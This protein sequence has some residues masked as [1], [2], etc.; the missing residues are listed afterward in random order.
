LKADSGEIKLDPKA[1]PS[2][3]NNE[4]I[5]KASY[6][7]A[8]VDYHTTMMT[9]TQA[10]TERFSIPETLVKKGKEDD[11][12]RLDA[13]GFKMP[14]DRFGFSLSS[15]SNPEQVYVSVAKQSSLLMMDKFMQIDFQLPSQRLFGF[16]E[17][18]RQ[19]LLDQGT[20]TM[21]ASGQAAAYDG[22]RGGN[23][24]SGVHPFVLVQSAQEDEFLGIFFR[25]SNAQSPIITFNEDGTSTLS[26]VTTGGQIEAYFFTGG[27]A[28][29]VIGRYHALIGVPMPPPF[30]ALGWQAASEGYKTQ[31][32]LEA[33]VQGF[34]AADLPVEGFWLGASYMDGYRDFSV[35]SS[36]FKNLGE[37]TQQL[38]A[39][40]R[41]LIVVVDPGLSADAPND[42][43][44]R[45]AE[46]AGALLQST[47]NPDDFGGALVHHVYSN[48]TVFLDFLSDQAVE[49]WS[50]GL[51][52]LYDEV[53]YDGLWLDMNEVT[54]LCD[55]E[56]PNGL[57]S[58]QSPAKKLTS[59]LSTS[60]GEDSGS[61]Y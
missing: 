45:Q 17:R 10:D 22:G 13:A 35:S 19:L 11:T 38:H 32:D 49:V 8:Q 41:R 6:T 61:W 23:Q 14:T 43:F 21:W 36:A 50:N 24:T 34:A 42:K 15:H 1:I 7:F 5:T 53:P 33:A 60:E 26:Y 28:K 56:C 57:S 2:G 9:L 20:Y 58:K 46:D 47:V 44:L 30:W 3:S 40:G 37:L 29:Q 55:G 48:K 59:L 51:T 39:S 54:G 52:E 12:M 16:G 31:A 4:V 18:N 25:N 27:S